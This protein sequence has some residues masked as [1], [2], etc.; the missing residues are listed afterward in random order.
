VGYLS[1]LEE[2]K[3]FLYDLSSINH[4]KNKVRESYY[5]R[6]LEGAAPL[7]LAPHFEPHRFVAAPTTNFIS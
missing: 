1:T 2:K 4:I 3:V 7:L 6:P 5:S